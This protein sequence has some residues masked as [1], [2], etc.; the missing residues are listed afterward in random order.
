MPSCA[1]KVP[2]GCTKAAPETSYEQPLS[3]LS[4][5]GNGVF[6][7]RSHALG[8]D[9]VDPRV[10]GGLLVADFDDDG[11]ADVFVTVLGERA[12]APSQQHQG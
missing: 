4:N 2:D 9:V 1:P 11:R 10:H 6:T 7:D 12:V 8:S 3:I 5:D